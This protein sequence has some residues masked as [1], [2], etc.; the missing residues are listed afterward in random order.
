MLLDLIA[1]VLVFGEKEME[2]EKELDRKRG[3][4]DDGF[5]FLS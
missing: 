4:Y 2:R 1:V 3:Q 5:N